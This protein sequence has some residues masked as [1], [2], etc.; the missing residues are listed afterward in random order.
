M[1]AVAAAEPP[2]PQQAPFRLEST[3]EAAEHNAELISQESYDLS[4]LIG[5]H[6]DSTIGYGSEFRPVK[7]LETILAPHPHFEKLRHLL[8][9]GMDYVLTR[10]LDD[11]TKQYEMRT[12]LARGNRQKTNRSKCQN[13]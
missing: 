10:E 5:R 2:V 4:T 12:L 13:Y 11:K 8:T 7:Q 6:G 9:V 1:T 3:A